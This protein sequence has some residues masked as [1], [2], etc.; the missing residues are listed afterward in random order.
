[1]NDA[2]IESLV[3]TVLMFL[4]LGVHST[5][6]AVFDILKQLV[7]YNEYIDEL[8]QEQEEIFADQPDAEFV[9]ALSKKMV[10]LDSFIREASRFRMMSL[11]FAHTY[12]GKEDAH[13][14]AGEV[15]R[16]GIDV[17]I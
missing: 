4:F 8:R 7:L 13:L 6:N 3:F 14:S 11:G 1:M 2:Y 5:S 10:K 17:F 15:I 12:I 9:H 16:P